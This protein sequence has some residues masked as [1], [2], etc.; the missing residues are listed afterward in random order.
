[1]YNLT[2]NPSA[3]ERAVILMKIVKSHQFEIYEWDKGGRQ[4]RVW[5]HIADEYYHLHIKSF[6]DDDLTKSIEIETDLG[7]KIRIGK[8]GW[9]FNDEKFDPWDYE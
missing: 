9:Y 4:N 7:D 5:S 8:R 6:S 1:M 2:N 3:D